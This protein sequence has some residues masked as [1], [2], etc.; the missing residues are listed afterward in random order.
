MKYGFNSWNSWDRLKECMV[1][2]VYP[3]DFFSVYKDKRI[4][5]AL[6]KVNED[7]RQ[8]IANL[9]NI[10]KSA[11]VK[12]IQTP[13]KFIDKRG[14]TIDDVNK[15]IE[16]SNTIQKPMLSPRD[17]FIVMG[18]TLVNTS[19]N[20]AYN[21]W[22]PWQGCDDYIN[23][24]RDFDEKWNDPEMTKFEETLMTDEFDV[25]APCIMRAGKDI[26]V[27]ISHHNKGTMEFA[28]TWLPKHMPNFRV[29]TIEMGGHSDAVICL[30]KPGLII[31]HRKVNNYD[32]LYPGWEVIYVDRPMDEYIDAYWEQKNNIPSVINYWIDGQESNNVLHEFIG[33]WMQVGHVYET[34]FNV[35]CLSIDESTLVC[36]YYDKELAQK[37]KKHNVE[38]VEAPMRHRHFWDCGVHCATVDLIREGECKDYFPTRKQGQF[39]GKP[40]GNNETRR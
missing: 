5:D 39:F 17:D 13:S 2:N 14:N 12:V 30:V 21:T 15:N 34:H 19:A 31:S 1:G 22:G 4:G 29:N 9:I 37:L 7:S 8:D 27:D 40:W 10:L 38:L 23:L 32:E 20:H 25:D 3:T 26:Q 24:T 35:N 28:N 33:K 16:Y 6:E 36:N 18:D 11:S